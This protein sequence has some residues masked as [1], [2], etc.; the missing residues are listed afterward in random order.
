MQFLSEDLGFRACSR[1]CNLGLG[2]YASQQRGLRSALTTPTLRASCDG[3]V[4]VAIS[5][6]ERG[7]WRL[8]VA[9]RRVGER[10]IE[11]CPRR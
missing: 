5:G 11:K 6:N 4:S 1:R 2:G 10:G 3:T 8:G 9:Q 7:C